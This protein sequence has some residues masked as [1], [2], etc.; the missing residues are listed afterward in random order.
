MKIYGI[1]LPYHK[2]EF[3]CMS[4]PG[5]AQIPEYPK[6]YSRYRTY[7]TK[8]EQLNAFGD[9][10][11]TDSVCFECEKDDLDNKLTELHNQINNP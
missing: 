6:E 5:Y 3:M 4:N 10:M 9:I 11:C 1:Y 2:S 7:K 8:I